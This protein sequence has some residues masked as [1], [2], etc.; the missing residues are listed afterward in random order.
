MKKIWRKYR[1]LITY[2]CAGLSTTLLN[3]LITAI[4]VFA[5]GK[6]GIHVTISTVVAWIIATAYAFFVYKLVVFCSKDMRLRTIAKE[7]SEFV[8][9]RI[10]TLLIET[11]GMNFFCVL[12]GFN[13]LVFAFDVTKAGDIVFQIP[14]SGYVF[15]KLLMLVVTTVLNYI[16]SK[17]IIFKKNNKGEKKDEE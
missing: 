6:E 1:E 13:D 10:L 15:S 4:Y 9:A 7:G 2:F 14:L 11:A 12:L 3:W 8:G 5:I 17:F 16:L